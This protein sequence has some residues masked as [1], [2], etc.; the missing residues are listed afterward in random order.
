MNIQKINK[1]LTD[2]RYCIDT[3]QMHINDKNVM[4]FYTGKIALLNKELMTMLEKAN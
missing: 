2:M 1:H 4:Q 3:M